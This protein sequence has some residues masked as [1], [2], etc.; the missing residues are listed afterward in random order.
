MYA[1][2][3]E[4]HITNWWIYRSLRRLAPP[5]RF[6]S[7]YSQVSA[8]LCAVGA[9]FSYIL[10]F[11]ISATV[12]RAS[13]PK[14]DVQRLPARL[15]FL[16]L[17]TLVYITFCVFKMHMFSLWLCTFLCIWL[18]DFLNIVMYSFFLYRKIK[19]S[20][21]HDMIFLFAAKKKKVSLFA[22]FKKKSRIPVT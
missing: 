1:Y 18:R 7:L 14:S 20:V 6:P 3:F 5:T 19:H 12:M 16:H 11:S 22:F 4:I 17:C 15:Y 8:S 2:M 21:V 10:Y 13:I 9:C